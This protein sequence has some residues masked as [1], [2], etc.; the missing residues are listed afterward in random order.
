MLNDMLPVERTKYRDS[1]E[2]L[3]IFY[4]FIYLLIK[5]K[6][7]REMVYLTRKNK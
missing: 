6:E 5:L 1:S 3:R 7:V 4:L 2:I